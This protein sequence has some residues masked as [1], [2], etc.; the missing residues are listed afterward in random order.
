V[1]RLLSFFL[2]ALMS[3]GVAADIF[4]VMHADAPVEHL[5]REDVRDLYLGRSK[6]LP[7]GEFVR[8]YDRGE[9]SDIRADFFEH[10]AGMDLRQ[11]D[12]FWARLVF[13]G[14]MLPLEHVSDATE[15]ERFLAADMNTISYLA[16]PP[17]QASLKVVYTAAQ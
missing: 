2:S 16:S 6:V 5:S 15:L 10:L 1:K 13:A 8:I 7:N 17:E 4:V 9:R 11:V 12:A 3:Y 14:R